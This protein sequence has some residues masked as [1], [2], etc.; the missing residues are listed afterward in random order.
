[1][2]TLAKM[3]TTTIATKTACAAP[4]SMRV[5]AVP[6]SSVGYSA[7]LARQV[8]ALPRGRRTT[9]LAIATSRPVAVV[10]ELTTAAA[11]V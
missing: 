2:S 4:D 10:G 9:R 3:K 7:R 5:S 11:T 8:A 1:M 6:G